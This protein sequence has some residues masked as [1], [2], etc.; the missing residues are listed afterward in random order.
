[1]INCLKAVKQLK[2][3]NPDPKIYFVKRL[4]HPPRFPREIKVPYILFHDNCG[5]V[6]D[7]PGIAST[8]REESP[9]YLSR[10]ANE[11]VARCEGRPGGNVTKYDPGRIMLRPIW[12]KIIRLGGLEVSINGNSVLDSSRGTGVTETARTS[13]MRLN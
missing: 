5:I 13:V 1:M 2:V 4:D 10:V 3:H 8:F 7:F 6:F 11:L 9:D 12:I